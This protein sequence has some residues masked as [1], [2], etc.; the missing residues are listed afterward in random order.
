MSLINKGVFYIIFQLLGG[1]LGELTMNTL[2]PI[3]YRSEIG[4]TLV[5][6]NVSMLNA[7]GVEFIITFVLALTVFAC[8]DVKKN[9]K[10]LG[11]SYPLSVSLSVIIGAVFGVTK[12]FC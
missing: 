9:R 3:E 6:K 4:L 2:L 11:G 1:V 12:L 5:N 7:F 10:D 8:V